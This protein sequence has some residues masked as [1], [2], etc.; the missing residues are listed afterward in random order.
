M[1]TTRITAVVTMQVASYLRDAAGVWAGY[2]VGSLHHL[3][4]DV[5]LQTLKS[6]QCMD[7]GCEKHP[8]L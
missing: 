1:G 7:H 5:L 8:C 6:W 2:I 3:E 4:T